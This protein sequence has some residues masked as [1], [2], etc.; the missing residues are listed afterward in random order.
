MADPILKVE[1]LV[2]R[3][4][5]EIDGNM[6][7]ILS[8][9]ELSLFQSQ[10]IGSLGR[11]LDRYLKADELNDTGQKQLDFTLQ[12]LVEIIMAPVPIEVRAKLNQ[13]QLHS[14]I[15]AFTWLSLARKTKLAG[16]I[17][18]VV[19][20]MVPQKAAT[21]EKSSLDSSGSTAATPQAG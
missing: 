19:K 13:A 4:Q 12:G 9:D 15:E 8:P 17:S 20:S 7:E 3:P 16:A 6:Y 18:N 11:K 5:V 1:T 21:G 14:V 10:K 2:E